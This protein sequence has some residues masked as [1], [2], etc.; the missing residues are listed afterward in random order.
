[1]CIY[2]RHTSYVIVIVIRTY[3]HWTYINTVQTFMAVMAHM[4]LTYMAYM[5]CEHTYKLTLTDS[6][7][8]TLFMQYK[9]SHFIT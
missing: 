2:I 3:I 6:K 8:L 9:T 1:M 7:V 4:T 5:A